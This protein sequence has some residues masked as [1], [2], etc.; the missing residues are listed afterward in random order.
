MTT[1]SSRPRGHD[2]WLAVLDNPDAWLAHFL[3][4]YE[5]HRPA[6]MDKGLAFAIV[7]RIDPHGRD[8][9]TGQLYKPSTLEA[10]LTTVSAHYTPP[11]EPTL[12]R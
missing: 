2:Y 11:S 7:G 5:A 10:A 3:E 4:E 12:T 9:R 1:S 8:K 6:S